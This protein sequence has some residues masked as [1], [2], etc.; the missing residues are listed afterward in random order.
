MMETKPQQNFFRW[1]CLSLC[2]PFI[3]T[4]VGCHRAAP[5]LADTVVFASVT[6]V[7]FTERVDANPNNARHFAVS[8][9]N[10]LRRLTTFAELNPKRPCKCIHLHEA[11]FHSPAGNLRAS[12][13]DHCFDLISSNR[14]DELEMPK[15]FYAE[16]Q[17]L[18]EQR[19]KDGW[20]SLIHT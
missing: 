13:C 12:F 16:F 19:S 1:F 17:K 20:L 9:S 7:V 15:E 5:P 4:A 8:D 14:V 2:I 11:L 6:N 10:E 18:A 3:I